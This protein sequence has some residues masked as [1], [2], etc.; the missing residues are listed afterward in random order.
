MIH[1]HAHTHMHA[2]THIYTHTHTHTLRD[3]TRS[4]R[5]LVHTV[6][7]A[8]VT[9]ITEWGLVGE[10]LKDDFTVLLALYRDTLCF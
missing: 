8:T 3:Q 5:V 2:H 1:T 10:H 7:N 9:K 4:H 6:K